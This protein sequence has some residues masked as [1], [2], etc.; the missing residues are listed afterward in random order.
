MKKEK[1]IKITSEIHR[2]FLELK[3]HTV[4]KNTHKRSL[5]HKKQEKNAFFFSPE[6]KYF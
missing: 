4:H 5:H 6:L 3:K 1:E 2:L